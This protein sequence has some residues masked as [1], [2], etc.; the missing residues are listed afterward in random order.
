MEK[1]NT[2]L[3][4]LEACPWPQRSSRIPFEG[5]SIGLGLGWPSFGLGLALGL[6]SSPRPRPF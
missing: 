2:S 6:G 3:D 5:F 1:L 4:A